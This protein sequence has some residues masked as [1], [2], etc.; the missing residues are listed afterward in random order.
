MINVLVFVYTC[1]ADRWSYYC[2]LFVIK[3]ETYEY[4]ICFYG[5]AYKFILL[6]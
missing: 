6:S 2:I 3:G 4:L 5:F 1:Y